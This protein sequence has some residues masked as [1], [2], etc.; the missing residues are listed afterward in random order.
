VDWRED[1]DVGVNRSAEDVNAWRK[2]DPVARLVAGLQNLGLINPKQ[3]AEMEVVI[4]KEVAEAGSGEAEPAGVDEPSARLADAAAEYV[5]DPLPSAD[6]LSAPLALPEA[7]LEALPA[8]AGE[9]D[10]CVISLVLH[11]LRAPATALASVRKVLA[12]QG[13][14]IVIDMVAHYGYYSLLAMTMNVARTALPEGTEGVSGLK[15]F[16]G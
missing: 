2:R 14:V 12:K 6:A 11:H 1:I 4:A 5:A 13:V 8:K 16:P 10:A 15:A 7:A 3:T 9:F